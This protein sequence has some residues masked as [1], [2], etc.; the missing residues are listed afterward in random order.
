MPNESISEFCKKLKK[1]IK[2]HNYLHKPYLDNKDFYYIKKTL[3]KGEVSTY[4]KNTEIFEK[5]LSKYLGVPYVVSTVDGTTSLHAILSHLNLGIDDEILVQSLTFVGTVN[6]ILYVGASPHFVESCPKTLAADPLKL[7]YY[8][9]SDCFIKKGK[10]LFNKK[11]NKKIKALIITHIY[12]YPADIVKLKKIAKKFNLTLI[13]DAAE[14]IGTSFKNKKIGTFGDFSFLSFNG[15][16]TITTGAGG[17][18]ICKKKFDYKRIKHAITTSK[19]K[20]SIVP[21]HDSMGFNYRMP[22]LNASLGLSQLK[23]LNKILKAKLKVFEIYV[24]IS[25]NFSEY[26]NVYFSNNPKKENNHWMVIIVCK[27][28]IIRNNFLKITKKYEIVT[29]PIWKPMH[30]LKYL[31]HFPKMKLK[32]VN[33]LADHVICLPSSPH[34]KINQ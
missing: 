7:E 21:D 19:I 18:I 30:K 24:S 15:N 13:E 31:S 34:S 33:T 28:K 26:F 8:L 27:N 14:T 11:T 2:F 1:K 32:I 3:K 29:K 17:A 20:K 16:K 10:N 6:P 4:G 9:K 12:G 23:K 22:S 25:K 5:K